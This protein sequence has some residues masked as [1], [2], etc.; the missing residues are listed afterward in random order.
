MVPTSIRS[1]GERFMTAP[2]LADQ[3][4]QFLVQ[5]EHAVGARQRGYDAG[6]V[7][8][9]LGGDSNPV[10]RRSSDTHQVLPPAD[11]LPWLNPAVTVERNKL[12]GIAPVSAAI[13][14]RS[15][16]AKVTKMR[17]PST[18]WPDFSAALPSILTVA[19]SATVLTVPSRMAERPPNSGLSDNIAALRRHTSR[20]RRSSPR[21][22]SPVP[23]SPSWPVR[24]P[25]HRP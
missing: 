9:M 4:R 5:F 18:R 11:F 7:D 17:A 14:G 15:T 10:P 13:S 24:G 20:R 6:A 25:G 23:G 16:W 19:V 2:G 21:P 12:V 22:K 1:S 8:R 3:L